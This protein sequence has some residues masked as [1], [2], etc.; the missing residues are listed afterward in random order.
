MYRKYHTCFVI[1][2]VSGWVQEMKRNWR[3]RRNRRISS[4]FPNLHGVWVCGSEKATRTS[5]LFTKSLHPEVPGGCNNDECW[6][7]REEMTNLSV[8]SLSWT[9]L[10]SWASLWG[11]ICSPIKKKVVEQM[12]HSK[13]AE[14]HRALKGLRAG[15]RQFRAESFAR[16]V[17]Q[18]CSLH[19]WNIRT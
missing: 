17:L 12:G 13:D 8:E 16:Y 2:G 10:W 15:L 19:T 5:V 7:W 11:I 4:R 3:G 1:D 9:K 18:A 6:W 14:P